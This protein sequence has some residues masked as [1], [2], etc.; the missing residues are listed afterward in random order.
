M[1]L[2]DS[3]LRRLALGLVR[4]A[5]WLLP[6]GRGDWAT[7]MLAELQHIDD[8]GSALRWAVGCVIAVIRQRMSTM[9]TG[10]W[11][12]S[13]W[14]VAPEM[15]LCFLPLTFAW[16]GCIDIL[17]R[18]ILLPAP[19]VTAPWRAVCFVIAALITATLGPAG[20]ISA[21]RLVALD[22]PISSQWLRAAFIAGPIFSGALLI[23][24]HLT[25]A[26]SVGFDFWGGLLL[27][28]GLPLLG[29]MHLLHLSTHDS[30]SG[31]PGKLTSS[32]PLA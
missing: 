20:L 16:L 26:T 18:A 25:T 23:T 22:R 4:L 17:G 12:I 9:T 32:S 10:D 21:F 24:E 13:R 29:A 2:T 8:E 27:L 14:I 30:N 7:A 6:Q 19:P 3:P 1:T 31:Q 5:V 15:L 11:R 28:S